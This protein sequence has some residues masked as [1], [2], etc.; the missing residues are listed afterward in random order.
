[1]VVLD[2]LDLQAVLER[3]DLLVAPAGLGRLAELGGQDRSDPPGV[4]ELQDLRE[5]VED[6]GLPDRQEL[7][8]HLEQPV[9]RALLELAAGQVQRDL[10]VLSE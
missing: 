10:K 1:M 6:V 2:R 5:L 7:P 9:A 3:T 4:S 8:E